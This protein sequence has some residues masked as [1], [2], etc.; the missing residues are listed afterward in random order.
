MTRN[1][2]TLLSALALSTTMAPAAFA[3]AAA[4]QGFYGGFSMGIT[5]A[6]I[7]AIPISPDSAL[8][9][10]IFV[11]YNHALSPDWVIGG[12]LSYGMSSGHSFSGSPIAFDLDSI[13]T[14]SARA[15]YVFGDT[16]IYGRVGYQ[17]LSLDANFSS[18]TFD[19]DGYVLGLGVEHMFAENISGRIEV[20]RSYL[21]VTGLGVP[22]GTDLDATRISIGVAFH[23]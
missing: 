8:S 9:G 3:D 14:I 23:F 15:G 16:M 21:D 13:L 10:N 11:G 1:F 18:V 5:S 2:K 17:T 12:E 7:S 20:S 4:F 22:P 19:A 6:D